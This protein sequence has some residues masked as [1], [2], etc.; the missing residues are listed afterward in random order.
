MRCTICDEPFNPKRAA[1]GYTTCL[2][3]GEQAARKIVDQRR[4]QLAP[5]YNKGA[6]QFI[7]PG[8]SLRSLGKKV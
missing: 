7:T 2:D 4:S 5:L 1:L 8:D 3:C 6:Y